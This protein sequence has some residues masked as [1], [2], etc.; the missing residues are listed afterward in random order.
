MKKS[1]LATPFASI[2]RVDFRLRQQEMKELL[3]KQSAELLLRRQE[4]AELWGPQHGRQPG[5][6][7][8][9]FRYALVQGFGRQ[10]NA[11]FNIPVKSQT[12]SPKRLRSGPKYCLRIGSASEYGLNAVWKALRVMRRSHELTGASCEC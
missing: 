9:I 12:S 8:L 1:C 10:K 5:R 6:Q 7:A 2:P 4:L 3:R 11:I